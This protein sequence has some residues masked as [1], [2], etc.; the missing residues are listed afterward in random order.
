MRTSAHRSCHNN[1]AEELSR[2]GQNLFLTATSGLV[3]YT[4]LLQDKSPYLIQDW[5]QVAV[6]A[7]SPNFSSSL[8]PNMRWF[9]TQM[10]A[11]QW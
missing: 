8:Y 10:P 5:V 4:E 7:L 3:N 11:L 2:D 6:K 1:S 9:P